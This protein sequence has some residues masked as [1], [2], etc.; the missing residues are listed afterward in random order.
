MYV[1]KNAET[2]FVTDIT[3][4]AFQIQKEYKDPK[5]ML[6]LTTQEQRRH[7]NVT[8]CWVFKKELNGDSVKDHCHIT[9]KYHG[10]V[11]KD[12]NLQLQIKA[13]QM[14]IPVIFHNLSGYDS[15]I[16]MKGIGQWNVQMISSQSHITWKNIWLLSSDH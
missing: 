3:R 9:G 1:G 13:R 14:H 8:N 5:P 15:H 12:C 6:P 11:H 7:N 10:L 4:E 2:K 16:I